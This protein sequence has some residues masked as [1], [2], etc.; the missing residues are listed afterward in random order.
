MAKK[1]QYQAKIYLGKGMAIS[2]YFDTT[3]E[4]KEWA[5]GISSKIIGMEKIEF[6]AVSDTSTSMY[7]IE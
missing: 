5:K 4:A 6:G 1:I 3:K 2:K 7:K